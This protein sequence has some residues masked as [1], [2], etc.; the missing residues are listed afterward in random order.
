MA[1]AGGSVVSN[2]GGSYDVSK[3]KLVALRVTECLNS[4]HSDQQ[5]LAIAM[6][7]MLLSETDRFRLYREATESMQD[8]TK[9]IRALMTLM[10][11]DEVGGG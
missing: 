5:K 7:S 10:A 8:T 3:E 1:P 9:A 11:D 2:I 6:G 4:I